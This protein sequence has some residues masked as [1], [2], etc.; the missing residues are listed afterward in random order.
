MAAAL[1]TQFHFGVI[2]QHYRS[3]VQTMGCNRRERHGVALRHNDRSA[4]AERVCSRSCRC[5]HNESVGLISGEIFAIDASVNAYHRRNVVFQYGYFVKCKRIVVYLKFVAR[6]PEHAMVLYRILAGTYV[7]YG[8][9]HFVGRERRQKSQASCVYSQ[10]RNLFVAHP[11]RHIQERSVSAHTHNNVGIEVIS[12]N[13]S[14]KRHV[15]THF[16]YKEIMEKSRH[17][18]L[19]PM[20]PHSLQETFHRLLLMLLVCIAKES[21]FHIHTGLRSKK[22]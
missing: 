10:N 16:P 6:N 3:H 7:S 21:E 12:V 20:L 8:F 18:Q 13:N 1:H 5:A 4:H 19:H 9:L 15:H 2:A 22:L 17:S 14:T 11:A